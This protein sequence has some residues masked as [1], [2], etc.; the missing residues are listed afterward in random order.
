[1]FFVQEFRFSCVARMTD[2]KI[3]ALNKL[4]KDEAADSNITPVFEFEVNGQRFKIVNPYMVPHDDFVVGDAIQI[5]YDPNDPTNSQIRDKE[6]LPYAASVL[7]SL[8][9]IT[10]FIMEFLIFPKLHGLGRPS[11]KKAK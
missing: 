10:T 6:K 11:S 2:G 8:I 5:M 7:L 3:I 1:M 9:A 4:R